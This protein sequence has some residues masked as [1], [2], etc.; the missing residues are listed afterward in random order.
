M[1]ESPPQ[2]I[3]AIVDDNLM[4]V[5]R[6]ELQLRLN[7]LKPKIFS[8]AVPTPEEL[9]ALAP[10]LILV[11]LSTASAFDL[12]RQI[13][14]APG[15]AGIPVVAYAG[16]KET[17]LLDAGKAAGADVTAANSKV[18]GNLRAVLEQVGLTPAGTHD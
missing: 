2:R 13:K 10:A 4:F 3:G 16:H 6:V 17:A 1:S 15:L 11:N 7:G 5:S 8:L 12:V 14:A 18:A 9:A